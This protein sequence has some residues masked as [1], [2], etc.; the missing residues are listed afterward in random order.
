MWTT[1]LKYAVKIAM[2]AANH[3]AEV[4]AAVNAAKELKAAR[5]KK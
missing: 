1:I 3:P 5:E 4:E 2:W